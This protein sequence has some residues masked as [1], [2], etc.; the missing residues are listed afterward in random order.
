MGRLGTATPHHTSFF[1]SPAIATL[2]VGSAHIAALRLH[3]SSQRPPRSRLASSLG[4]IGAGGALLLGKGKYILGA[5]KL[6]KF[7]SLGSM[8]MTVGA[9]T[10]FYGAPYAV[11]M[12]RIVWSSV[13]RGSGPV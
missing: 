5:L 13:L 2:H 7:A 10:M 3:S 9:Y 4:M 12:V 8:V 1:P 11:G 6:T